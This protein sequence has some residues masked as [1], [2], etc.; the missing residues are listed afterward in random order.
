MTTEAT[1]N[2]FQELLKAIGEA[3]TDADTLAK[4]KG[5]DPKADDKAIKTAAADGAGEDENEDDAEGEGENFGKS[6]GAEFVDAT[7]LIK[8]LQDKLGQHDEV[9]TKGL[10][11]LVSTVKKQGDLVKSLQAEVTELRGQG[12][13]RK[14][15]FMAVE[16]PGAGQQTMAKSEGAEG[17]NGITVDEFFT[18]ADA[19]YAAG[20]I[21]GSELTT[22]D[23]CRRMGQMPDAALI[24]KVA[25]AS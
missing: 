4:A 15:V 18:K 12:R 17:G 6:A 25:L 16:K 11:A 20:K 8:S 7:D 23:V 22:L 14:A 9:L 19:A 21:T 3:E 24:K 5:A 2:N 1:S 10:T 13:G